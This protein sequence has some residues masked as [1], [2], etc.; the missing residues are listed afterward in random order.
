MVIKNP[1]DNSLHKALD[2]LATGKQK[3]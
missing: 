3:V 1:G 2:F